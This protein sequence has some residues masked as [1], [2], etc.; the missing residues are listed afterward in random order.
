MR[1][2]YIED[3]LHIRCNTY[4]TYKYSHLLWNHSPNEGSRTKEQ[5]DKL[6]KMGMCP[7]WADLE[8]MDGQ[9]VVFIELKTAVGKQSKAQKIMQERAE[10]LGYKYYLCREYEDFIAILEK[11]FGVAKDPDVEQL[12]KIICTK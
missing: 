2:R 7:G 1:K 4:L 5:G 6:K 3:N 10:A 9:K 11:E 8:I 12:R